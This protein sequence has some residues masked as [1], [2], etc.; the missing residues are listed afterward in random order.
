MTRLPLITGVAIAL[1]ST[2]S[3][4]GQNAD[5]PQKPAEAMASMPATMPETA[6]VSGHGDGTVKAINIAAGTVALDHGPIPAAKWPAMTMNFKAD[7]ALLA[8][9]A[10]GDK[11]EFD[12]KMADGTAEVV[13]LTRN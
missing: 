8:G 5:A 12:M 2:L 10:V 7:P 4:C 9:V 1:T 3:A 6:P 13:T 11:V